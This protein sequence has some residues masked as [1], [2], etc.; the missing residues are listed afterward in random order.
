ME[1]VDG[2]EQQ[3]FSNKDGG[4]AEGW[5]KD[6]NKRCELVFPSVS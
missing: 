3:K 1:R 6:V 5:E 2:H 4:W